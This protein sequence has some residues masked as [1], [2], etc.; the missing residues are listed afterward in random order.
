MKVASWEVFVFS[1]SRGMLQMVEEEKDVVWTE[2]PPVLF[3]YCL[4]YVQ[5][6]DIRNQSVPLVF[7]L[8][9]LP[10]CHKRSGCFYAV[11]WRICG[12]TAAKYKIYSRLSCSAP[13]SRSGKCSFQIKLTWCTT[14]QTSGLKHLKNSTLLCVNTVKTLSHNLRPT[15]GCVVPQW[16]SSHGAWGNLLWGKVLTVNKSELRRWCCVLELCVAPPH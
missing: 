15:I 12:S 13:I 7:I 5:C 16:I 2:W 4:M 14:F 10:L 11:F 9:W 8:M 1:C 6:C 3:Y